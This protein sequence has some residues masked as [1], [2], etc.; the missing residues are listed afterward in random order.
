MRGYDQLQ[1]N[2]ELLLD[3][4]LKEAT[5]TNAQDWAKPHH[6]CTL[7]GTPTWQSLDN[8]LGYLDFVPGNPDYIRSLQAA[9]TD[10]DFTSEAFSA[11]VWVRPDAL[12]NR[13]FMTR[14]V[15]ATDGWDWWMDVNGAQNVST[16]QAAASQF[17]LSAAADLVVGTWRMI[18]FAR[19]GAAVRTYKNGQDTT[20]T[21]A[22]H[23]DPLTANRNFYIGVNNLAAAGWYDGD[24]WRPRIWGKLMTAPE[25]RLLFEM[26][27]G[28]FG[29]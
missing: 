8:D 4:Q 28:L 19:T 25:F 7:V 2:Q 20:A 24:L 26:E 3:L 16:F 6:V 13:N 14:G 22:T 1:A 12:G 17:T 9:S 23:I 10:L 5:G 11:V 18:G 29:V 27:R 15:A 21:S